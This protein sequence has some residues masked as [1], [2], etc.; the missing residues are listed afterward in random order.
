MCHFHQ[1]K[2]NAKDN[3]PNELAISSPE[4]DAQMQELIRSS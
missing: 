3:F 4:N 1:L 2:H